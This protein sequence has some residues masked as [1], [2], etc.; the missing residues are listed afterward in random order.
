MKYHV[1][2]MEGTD[3]DLANLWLNS[4][5]RAEIS[6]DSRIADVSLS[7][8]PEE[9]GESREEGMRVAFFG[10]L[11]IRFRVYP[12]DALVQVLGV[13]KSGRRN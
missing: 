2:W 6:R 7:Q 13:W 9:L 5:N 10:V 8:N 3:E 4:E 1:I 12:D 11:G